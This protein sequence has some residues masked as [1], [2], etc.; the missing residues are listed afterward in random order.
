M[1][2]V[3]GLEIAHYH[4]P[5]NLKRTIDWSLSHHGKDRWRKPSLPKFATGLI[6]LLSALACTSPVEQ[7]RPEDV[8][9]NQPPLADALPGDDKAPIS[10][11]EIQAL[12]SVEDYSSDFQDW[13]FRGGDYARYIFLNPSEFWLT[14]PLSPAG[15]VRLLP[16]ANN[17]DLANLTV[18]T[19]A[20][21]TTIADYVA[22][23]NVDGAIVVHNGKIVFED[24]PRMSAGDL[25]IWFSVSK[26][27]VSTSVAILE[28]RGLIDANAP[29]ETYLTNLQGTAWEGIPVV[30]ILDMASGIDCPERHQERDNCFWS[31]YA[32]LENGRSFGRANH[33]H[34]KRQCIFRGRRCHHPPGLGAIRIAIYAL[35]EKGTQ[36]R[37]F[38]CLSR[39]DSRP[40]TIRLTLPCPKGSTSGARRRLIQP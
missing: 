9:S 36:S 19:P 10:I 35:R 20:G 6:V 15:E 3:F 33:Q 1:V 32:G 31:F 5:S 26:T 22:D 4:S 11:A 14:S 18:K 7:A 39:Q 30:D 40:E 25:H 37:R 8:E 16:V 34:A 28:D 21:E 29:I 27:F 2:Y 12:F 24:Y 23:S 17:Q 13:Y 38:R